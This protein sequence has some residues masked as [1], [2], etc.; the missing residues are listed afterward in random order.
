MEALKQK[1]QEA[2]NQFCALEQQK[3]EVIGIIVSG[4]FIHSTIDLYS[5]IDVYV[6]LDPSC[7][8]RE[9]GNTWIKGVEIEYFQNPPEQ[10]RA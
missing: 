5:D 4:S 10:I 8:Y 9:R 1:F 3:E 2:C 7:A 6:I